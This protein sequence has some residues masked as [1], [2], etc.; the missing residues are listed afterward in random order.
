MFV[1]E[2]CQV[3]KDQDRKS[4]VR[5]SNSSKTLGLLP[6]VISHDPIKS[7]RLLAK[8]NDNQKNNMRPPQSN[9]RVSM[10][11]NSCTFFIHLVLVQTALSSRLKHFTVLAMEMRG[12]T[13]MNLHL[14]SH[15]ISYLYSWKNLAS[16]NEITKSRW[17]SSIT[18]EVVQV[19]GIGISSSNHWA[20]MV[21]QSHETCIKSS[22][23]LGSW[24]LL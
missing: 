19:A 7:H 1:L 5:K 9:G 15:V 8:G 18:S 12:F 23:Y 14:G 2:W 11:W 24:M 16:Q 21:K 6:V 3:E 13:W 22:H 20:Q 4:F 10:P 17:F